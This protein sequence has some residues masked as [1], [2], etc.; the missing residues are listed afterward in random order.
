MIKDRE[1][2]LY[3]HTFPNGKR[4]IG[5][6]SQK[7][8]GRWGEDGKNY[9]TQSLMKRAIE[10]YGWSNV[11]HEVLFTE[12]TKEEAINKEIELI[13]KYNTTDRK[14]GYNVGTGGEIT[15]T[16]IP[17]I[18]LTTLEH[19]PTIAAGANR[20]NICKKSL[21]GYLQRCPGSNTH[22]CGI[23]DGKYLVWDFYD[24]NKEYE[25]VEYIP[26]IKKIICVS[27]GEVFDSMQD[28]QRKKE[29]YSWST[30]QRH[31]AGKNN[32][33]YKDSDGNGL[34]WDF[35]DESKTYPRKVFPKEKIAKIHSVANKKKVKKTP[36]ICL[37]NLKHYVSMSDGSDDMGPAATHIY[38]VC[39][40]KQVF[41]GKDKDTG[42]KLIWSFYNPEEKY[43]QI[44]TPHIDIEGK[45]VL[46]ITTGKEFDSISSVVRLYKIPT[47]E[48]YKSCYNNGN[49]DVKGY[50]FKYLE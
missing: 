30:I 45:K 41:S 38:D 24:E 12:L 42:T 39:V 46:C 9:E 13:E 17:V 47:Y 36:V 19:F 25:K 16:T 49:Y 20:Y 34:L 8:E 50:K 5:I 44:S 6:T 18:C 23:C 37:F 33:A 15:G 32:Y 29:G 10:K 14:Y 31:L 43:I 2:C 22:Y 28:V 4:Y 21:G 27:T 35:Y 40:G 1:Y 48:V 11:K 7:P 3:I 26:R